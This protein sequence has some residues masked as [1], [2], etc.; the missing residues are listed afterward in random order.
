MRADDADFV[1]GDLDPLRERPQM[2][3]PKSAVLSTHA[4]A[5]EGDESRQLRRRKALVG[6]LDGGPRTLGIHARLIARRLQ[7]LDPLFQRRIVEV[8][9]PAADISAAPWRDAKALLAHV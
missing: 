1:L 5:G 3:T 2:V 4:A 6:S 9:D 7:F 8:R